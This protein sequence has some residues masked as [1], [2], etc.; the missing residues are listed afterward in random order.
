MYT[1]DTLLTHGKYKFI[2]LCRIPAK[3]LLNVYNSKNPTDKD[4]NEYIERNLD[5]IKARQNGLIT[6]PVLKVTCEKIIYISKKEAKLE[7]NRIKLKVQENKKPIRTYECEKCGGWHLTSI[8]IED[9][10]IIS[11]N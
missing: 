4:L 1:D 3:Y 7:I 10:N 9:W 2:A 11:E 6:S 8:P 5:I